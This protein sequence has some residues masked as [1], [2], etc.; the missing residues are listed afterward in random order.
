MLL[1]V[2]YFQLLCYEQKSLVQDEVLTALPKVVNG[3]AVD[4]CTRTF[5]LMPIWVF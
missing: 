1:S 3:N 5:C 4:Q 2:V